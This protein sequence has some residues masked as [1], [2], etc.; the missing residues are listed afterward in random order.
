MS[1]AL[2]SY[3][4]TLVIFLLQKPQHATSYELQELK[5][6][7][8]Y[9]EVLPTF[10]EDPRLRIDSYCPDPNTYSRI[11]RKC[12]DHQQL[13]LCQK[14]LKGESTGI[15]YSTWPETSRQFM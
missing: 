9:K 5:Y 3:C 14:R 12:K 13:P 11:T 1:K 2:K 6:P 10:R 8:N 4:T 15:R 7:T